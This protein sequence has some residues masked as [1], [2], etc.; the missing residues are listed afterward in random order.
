M[1]HWWG[2]YTGPGA[3]GGANYRDKLVH[4]VDKRIGDGFED[5]S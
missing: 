3:K 2:N 1:Q 4:H 5:L